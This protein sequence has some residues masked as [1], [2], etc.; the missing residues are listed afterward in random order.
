MSMWWFGLSKAFS[1]STMAVTAALVSFRSWLY[2]MYVIISISS[3][4]LSCPLSLHIVSSPLYLQWS[5]EASLGQY[6][7]MVCLRKGCRKLFWVHFTF[8]LLC[9]T[10]FKTIPC[11]SFHLVANFPLGL[12]NWRF[13]PGIVSLGGLAKKSRCVCVCVS[14]GQA[15][16]YVPMVCVCPS[17]QG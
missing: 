5:E 1:K 4:Y 7:Q 2:N 16:P 13:S 9:F 10:L 14:V 11:S 3:G 15:G 6:F 17:Q 8:W 12:Y